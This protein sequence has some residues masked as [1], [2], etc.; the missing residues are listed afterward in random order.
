MW[1]VNIIIE[2]PEVWASERGERS[3]RAG[4]MQL[5]YFMVGAVIGAFNGQAP[6]YA[7]Y[8]VTAAKWKGQTPKEI[9][10]SRCLREWQ[11]QEVK[12]FSADHNACEAALLGL[13]A[14]KALTANNSLPY[15]RFLRIR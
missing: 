3:A 2:L 14:A 15:D 8:G 11:R 12:A 10:V 9:M 5:V 13:Q 6:A 7:A 1:E 4:S